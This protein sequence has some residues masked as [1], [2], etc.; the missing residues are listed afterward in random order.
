MPA[1]DRGYVVIRV[2]DW[3]TS[4]LG[5]HPA[6]SWKELEARLDLKGQLAGHLDDLGVYLHGAGDYDEALRFW[7]QDRPHDP[8][9]VVRERR[10]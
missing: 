7:R 4:H 2:P 9:P 6:T 1:G 8:M 10:L 5:W 3:L